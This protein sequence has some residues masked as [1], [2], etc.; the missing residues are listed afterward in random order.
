MRFEETPKF[1]LLGKN[2]EKLLA[3]EKEGKY[4]F[5]GSPAIIDTLAPKQALNKNQETGE[6]EPHGEPAVCATKHADLAIFRALTNFTDDIGPSSVSFGT[7]ENGK[8][9]FSASSNVL[10]LAKIKTG[11][12][13]I[14]NK[15]GFDLLIEGGTEFRSLEAVTPIEVM[16]VTFEDM[17]KNIQ[18]INGEK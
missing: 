13:Y 1:E 12:V 5:H 4:V 16:E 15:K 7:D 11:H 17:P 10:E 2:R 14:L 18:I 8:P 6:M 3:L 9:Q